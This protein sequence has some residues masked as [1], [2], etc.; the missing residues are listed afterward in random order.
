[1]K[2]SP[3]PVSPLLVLLLLAAATLGAAG[4]AKKLNTADPELTAGAYPEG[5]RDSLEHTPSNLTVWP[6]VGI[7]VV[8]NATSAFLFTAYRARAGAY[9]GIIA[10]YTGATAYQMFRREP[11]DA[12]FSFDDFDRAPARRFADHDYYGSTGGTL[13]LPPAQLYEFVD[14]FPPAVSSPAYVGRA[15]I[16]GIS[17]AQYPLTNLGVLPANATLDSMPYTGSSTPPDSLINMTW[18]AINGAAGYWVHVYQKRADI[19]NA[20]EAIITALPSPIA[21]GKVRDFFIGYIPAPATSYKLGN[22]VPVGGRVLAYRIINGRQEV[23]IRVSAVDASGRMLATTLGP[24]SDTD[25]GHV[26]IN[27]Q[28]VTVRYA[29]NARRVTPKSPIP[30]PVP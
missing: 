22:P 17:S 12:F 19:Q 28:D 6:D 11:N 16:T 14:E 10:D 9:A 25:A 23:F 29:I 21:T 18:P 24:D 13:V 27:G 8:D 20:N 5:T 15:L 3:L 1:M 26:T 30:P 7:D 4:C 2:R